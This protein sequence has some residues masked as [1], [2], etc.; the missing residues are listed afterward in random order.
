MAGFSAEGLVIPRQP[1]IVADLIAEEQ[2][3]IHPNVNTNSDEFLGQ[4][5]NVLADRLRLNYEYLEA[6]YSQ[7]RL[8]SAV[9]KALDEL[10]IPKN[11]SRLAATQ[12][13][14]DIILEGVN[15]TKIPSNSLVE[16][17]STKQR[18][19]TQIT[20]RILNTAAISVVVNITTSAPSTPFTI[21][22]DGIAYTRTTPGSG[23]VMATILGLLAG[24]INTAAVGVTAT[25]TASSISVVSN[26][27]TPFNLVTNSSFSLG[28]VKS[29]VQARSLLKGVTTSA[30][31]GDWNILSPVPG[32]NKTSPIMESLVAGRNDES[33]EDFRIRIRSSNYNLGKGTTR[34]VKINLRNTDGVSHA[35]VFENPTITPG[36]L[37]PYSIHCVI[38]GGDDYD[39]AKT[40]HETVGSGTTTLVGTSVVTYTDEFAEDFVIRF[41][42]PLPVP[43]DIRI[44]LVTFDEES[45]TPDHINIIKTS[46]VDYINNIGLGLDII[47]SHMYVPI[48]TNVTGVNVTNIEV[49]PAGSG[50][51]S[52]ARFTIDQDKFATT[53]AANVSIV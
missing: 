23:V 24:D 17:R 3:Q 36:V 35:D 16:D 43:I 22:I 2:I 7:T 41:S 1:E 40:I 12:S 9:G 19:L 33:D 53:T 39:I 32:W 6:A 30:T 14:V 26:T 13:S 20:K 10:A 48:Y 34:A 45:L 49:K 51:F 28:V 29:K 50:A 25:A 38:D 5:N 27:Y 46:V 52:N 37:P 44:T 8:S 21:T 18:Y 11:V 42:R 15:D 47:P 4:L 31:P